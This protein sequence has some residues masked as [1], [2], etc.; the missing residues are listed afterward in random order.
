MISYECFEAGCVFLVFSNMMKNK[1][2][3]LIFKEYVENSLIV[4]NVDYLER[5]E[6]TM[7]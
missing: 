2:R 4:S 1:K 3:K 5:A 7:F 6:C